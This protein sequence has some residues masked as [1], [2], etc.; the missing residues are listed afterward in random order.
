MGPKGRTVLFRRIVLRWGLRCSRLRRSAPLPP[1]PRCEAVCIQVW[2][3]RKRYRSSRTL[4]AH[5]LVQLLFTA[6]RRTGCRAVL[7]DVDAPTVLEA[8]TRTAAHRQFAFGKIVALGA[9]AGLGHILLELAATLDGIA[10]F[11][12]THLRVG[13]ALARFRRYSQGAALGAGAIAR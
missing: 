1:S 3:I 13:D 12:A 11:T 2:F 5:S 9:I 10:T 7:F 8:A 4:A 6:L